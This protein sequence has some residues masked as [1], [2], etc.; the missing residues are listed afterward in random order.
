MI[1]TA[2]LDQAVEIRRFNDF[3]WGNYDNEVYG[4]RCG[5]IKTKEIQGKVTVFS[6]GKLISTGAKSIENSIKQLEIAKDLL[7]RADFINEIK[8]DPKVRNIVATL[9]LG[10]KV[11]LNI[12]AT[13]LHGSTLEPEHFPGL[14]VKTI[15]RT[16]CLIFKTGKIVIVGAKTKEEIEKTINGLKYLRY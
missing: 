10:K 14:I 1:T 16:T 4:G 9:D 7:L 8:L 13:Q 2:D 11:N 6:S 15:F 3:P 5:Y 12:L